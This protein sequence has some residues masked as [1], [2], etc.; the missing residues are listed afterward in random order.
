MKILTI[1]KTINDLTPDCSGNF[2]KWETLRYYMKIRYIEEA[3]IF[4]KISKALI[5]LKKVP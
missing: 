2:H 4:V 3:K 1:A 5:E